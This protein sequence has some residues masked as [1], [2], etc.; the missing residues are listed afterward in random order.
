MSGSNIS[1]L[2]PLL[3][4]AATILAFSS[5]AGVVSAQTVLSSSEAAK[6]VSIKD[7]NATPSAVSG[8]VANH[9]PHAIRDIEILVQY[10]W[11]WGNEFKPGRQPPGES[12]IIKLDKELKPG[13]SVIFRHVPAPPLPERKDGRFTLEVTVAGFTVVIP[14]T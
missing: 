1:R 2:H 11:L 9:S 6:T 4:V 5:G 14:A 12:T 13:E 3:F 10:H 8:V 7:L